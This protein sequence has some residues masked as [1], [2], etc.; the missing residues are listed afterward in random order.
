MWG[1]L[2]VESLRHPRA[3]ARRLLALDPPM[4]EIA[5]A[6]LMVACLETV[7]LQ[8]A[9]RLMPADIAA[10]FGAEEMAPLATVVEQ[11]VVLAVAALATARIGALFG[12]KGTLKGAAI[13]VLWISFVSALFPLVAALLLALSP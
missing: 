8:V 2:I 3:A 12:G 5:A 10:A 7:V 9:L 4:G 13:V 11:L 1:A 6:A